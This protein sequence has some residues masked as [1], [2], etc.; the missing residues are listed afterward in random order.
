MTRRGW[1]F[2]LVALGVSLPALA[3]AASDDDE[4][5]R[6][7]ALVEENCARCH[8]IGESGESPFEPAPAF[9]TLHE[10]YPLE[11]LEEALAEGIVSGHP[12]MPEFTFDPDQ[13]DDV[14]AYLKTL[15]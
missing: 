15:R 10:R 5:A 12:A 2:V 13:I 6:G 7:L 9:R 14:I 4:V 11:D 1:G 8:A 3:S